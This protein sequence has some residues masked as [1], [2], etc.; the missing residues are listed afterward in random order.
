MKQNITHFF[1]AIGIAIFISFCVYN[2]LDAIVTEH[3]TEKGLN[4][5]ISN[6]KDSVSYYRDQFHT[7]H[8]RAD[9][10]DIN[11]RAANDAYS[12]L[13]DSLSK[14]DKVKKKNIQSVVDVVPIDQ[15]Q[16]TVPVR[17][18]TIH[19]TIAGKIE[20]IAVRDF[21]YMDSFLTESGYVDSLDAHISYSVKVPIRLTRIIKRH[22][23]LGKRHYYIDGYSDNPNIRIEGL[24]DIEIN[25]RGLFH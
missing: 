25:K 6:Q 17:V 10:L 22:W 21:N 13:L 1:I 5:I 11:Y 14:R 23:F 19:D 24:K 7:E 4:A 16:F 3:Q 20:S 12:K 15:G 9:Q 18:D 2:I 8:A